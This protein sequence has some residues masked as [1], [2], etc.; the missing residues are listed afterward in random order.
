MRTTHVADLELVI[1]GVVVKNEQLINDD[2]AIK[3]RSLSGKIYEGHGG[4]EA[5]GGDPGAA[6]AHT[7]ARLYE[8]EPDTFGQARN[9]SP[10]RL[11]DVLTSEREFLSRVTLMVPQDFQMIHRKCQQLNILR[12]LLLELSSS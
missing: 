5:A 6:H 10:Q 12:S 9:G 3:T 4:V 7:Q 2:K 1:N 8:T 11:K